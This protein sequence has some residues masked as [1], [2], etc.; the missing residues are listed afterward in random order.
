MCLVI[1][2][3]GVIIFFITPSELDQQGLLSKDKG[4]IYVG[5]V[6]DSARTETDTSNRV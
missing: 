4:G 1:V 3:A 2:Y 6:N 5:R